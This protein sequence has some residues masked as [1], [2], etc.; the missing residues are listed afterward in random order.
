MLDEK[1]DQGYDAIE[2]GKYFNKVYSNVDIQVSEDERR[3]L[4]QIEKESQ[5]L[6]KVNLSKLTQLDRRYYEAWLIDD[7]IE[8]LEVNKEYIFLEL[9]KNTESLL[10]KIKLGYSTL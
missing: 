1:G 9:T 8:F 6:K 10:Q 3:I 2:L 5:S 4:K 7:R